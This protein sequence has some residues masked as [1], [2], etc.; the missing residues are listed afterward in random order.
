MRIFRP[1]L[2]H[3]GFG[4][5]YVNFKHY[6]SWFGYLDR[7]SKS[8]FTL[9]LSTTVLGLYLIQFITERQ[10]VLSIL[11]SVWFLVYGQ[12]WASLKAS[13]FILS[14]YLPFPNCHVITVELSNFSFEIVYSCKILTT[15][16]IL[17]HPIWNS[18]TGWRQLS[19]RKKRFP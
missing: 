2:F 19:K 18:T 11:A 16:I 5:V 17:N 15:Y 13:H 1:F 14:V 8:F 3:D 6:A 7:Y 4:S 9:A 10:L 12:L